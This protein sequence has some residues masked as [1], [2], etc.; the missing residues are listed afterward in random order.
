[1]SEI[2]NENARSINLDFDGQQEE[3]GSGLTPAVSRMDEIALQAHVTKKVD[4]DAGLHERERAVVDEEDERRM[5]FKRSGFQRLPVNGMAKIQGVLDDRLFAKIVVNDKGER[6]FK[7]ALR[8]KDG[9]FSPALTISQYDVLTFM[10]WVQYRNSRADE[11]DEFV[12]ESKREA[13]K[14][15]KKVRK[16]YYNS[17]TDGSLINIEE[18]LCVLCTKQSELPVAHESGMMVDVKDLYLTASDFFAARIK[19]VEAHQAACGAHTGL[20]PYDRDRSYYV[21]FDDDLNAVVQHL[22]DFYHIPLDISKFVRQMASGGFLYTQESSQG[23]QVKVR[24]AGNPE[25]VYALYKPEYLMSGQSKYSEKA[26]QEEIIEAE[27]GRI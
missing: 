5:A 22:R 26:Y 14:I 21:L 27:N 15:Y 25:W 18:L 20:I 12:K 17:A 7:Y 23:Y 3:G 19:E 4:L 9:S 1:M 8:S 13:G 11:K 6:L 10:E 24:I 16:Q 2:T